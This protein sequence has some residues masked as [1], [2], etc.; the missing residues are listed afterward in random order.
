MKRIICLLMTVILGASLCACGGNAQEGSDVKESKSNYKLGNTVSTDIL[1]FTLDRAEAAT[2]LTNSFTTGSADEY[3]TP[4]EYSAEEDGNNSM[5]ASVGHTLIYFSYTANNL[6]RTSLDF[7]GFG[8][9]KFLEIKYAKETYNGDIKYT[10]KLTSEDV[11]WGTYSSSNVLLS[12]GEK[13][14]YRG[15]V[16]IPVEIK[17]EDTFDITFFLPNSAGQTEEFVYTVTAE[18]SASAGERENAKLEEL[19]AKAANELEIRKTEADAATVAAVKEAVQGN[20]EYTDYSSSGTTIK[21]ELI[22]D[23]DKV[24]VNST[25]M[26]MTIEKTGVYTICNNDIFIDFT[27]ESFIDCFIPYTYENGSF[28][29]SAIENITE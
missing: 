14:S 21:Q 11:H 20:W 26:G 17:K 3:G 28:T 16:D 13:N 4:K 7:G 24:T 10:A 6:D 27:D 18:D 25:T 19:A 22:F 29:M 9:G 1:E 15:Y 8:S 23:G 5:V 12:S 2:A